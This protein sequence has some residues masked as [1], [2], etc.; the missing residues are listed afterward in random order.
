[1]VPD[2]RHKG[3]QIT[4]L[5]HALKRRAPLKVAVIHCLILYSVKLLHKSESQQSRQVAGPEGEK[6]RGQ[7]LRVQALKHA[8]SLAMTFQ[9]TAKQ[10]RAALL[11]V[12]PSV[13]SSRSSPREDRHSSNPVQNPEVKDLNPRLN[14]CLLPT[15]PKPSEPSIDRC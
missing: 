11:V 15:K 12:H 7:R 3:S 2:L 6:P 10:L 8:L 5:R 4:F 9:Y 13:V 1:V 14:W